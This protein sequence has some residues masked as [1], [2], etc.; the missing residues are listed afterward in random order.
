MRKF[1]A[2]ILPFL[3]I[4]YVSAKPKTIN[5]NNVMDLKRD[6]LFVDGELRFGN[7]GK[8]CNGVIVGKNASIKNISNRCIFENVEILGCWTTKDIS[9][10]WFDFDEKMPLRNT[11]NF[12]NLIALTQDT[13]ENTVTITKGLY[14][15]RLAKAGDYGLFLKSKT[16]LIINGDIVLEPNDFKHCAIIRIQQCN[17]IQVKG[18]GSIT[19]DVEGHLGNEGEWGMGISISSSKNVVVKDIT[20]RH[21]WGDC[22]YIGQLTKKR[23][24]YSENITIDNVKCDGG[25]RQGLSLIT[26]KNIKIINS[27]FMNTGSIKATPPCAGIDIEPN[28]DDATLDNIV[29]EK[30]IFYGNNN[31][32]YGDIHTYNVNKSASVKI[33]KCT[34]EGK[35]N[36]SNNCFNIMIKDCKLKGINN[37]NKHKDSGIII[38]NVTVEKGF[39]S[40]TKYLISFLT[41]LFCIGSYRIY[42]KHNST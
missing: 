35:I 23:K 31:T 26:G 2:I 3:I 18:S 21:C 28:I 19:G 9:S 11:R 40:N 12:S 29:I 13:I 39:P 24:D 25:R 6:T 34:L 32:K 20:I 7:S 38:T 22:I 4:V 8:I 15:I 16:K 37:K 1:F 41:A 30:C 10:A 42:K 14:P 27:V 17:D 33:L 36:I 5:I